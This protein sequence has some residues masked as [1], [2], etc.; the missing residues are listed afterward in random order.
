M[1]RL[2]AESAAIVAA[3]L[4]AP[5]EERKSPRRVPSAGRRSD[6]RPR[7]RRRARER[8][9]VLPVA[10]RDLH[11]DVILVLRVVDG[12]NL[13]LPERVVE[14][15]VDRVEGQA[16]AH[17]RVAVDGDVG[18]EAALLLVGIDV[19]EDVAVHQRLGQLRRPLIEFRRVVGEQRILIGRV[20]LP[21][22]GPQ[23]GD[24]DH[25]QPRACDLRELAAQAG[26]DVV[27]SN[28]A[29]RIRLERDIDEAGVRLPPAG[30]SDDARDRR[31]VLNDVCNC[32]SF[33]FI[34][35]NE[36]LWS[37]WIEPMISPVS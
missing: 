34:D 22:A 28:L 17:R 16:Q 26:H 1:A 19:L 20:A 9:R 37:A 11:D 31:I 2:R 13:P 21:P 7:S 3:V 12:R 33:F 14:R 24:S 23:I 27:G 35:W 4:A 29:L 8:A 5:V 32:A 25:E 15:V 30:E 10:R 6:W 18:L 36:M